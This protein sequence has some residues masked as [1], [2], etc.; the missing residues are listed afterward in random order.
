MWLEGIWTSQIFCPGTS[1]LLLSAGKAV[2]IHPSAP[3]VP[4][5]LTVNVISSVFIQPEPIVVYLES[6]TWVTDFS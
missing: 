1:W 3:S 4:S 5:Q 6:Q 2:L